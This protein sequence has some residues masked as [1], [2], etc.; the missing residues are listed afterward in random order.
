V[1][2]IVDDDSGTS[3]RQGSPLRRVTHNRDHLLAGAEQLLDGVTPDASRGPENNDRTLGSNRGQPAGPLTG[4]R[5]LLCFGPAVWPADAH[6]RP[7]CNWKFKE[8]SAA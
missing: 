8:E 4:H 7:S 6:L 2:Q 5:C 1:L 3:L